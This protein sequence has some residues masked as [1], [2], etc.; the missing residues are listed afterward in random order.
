MDR[1]VSISS[2]ALLLTLLLIFTMGSYVLRGISNL[3]DQEIPYAKPIQLEEINIQDITWGGL[4]AIIIWPLI[5]SQKKK[6]LAVKE[7]ILH[8]LAATLVVFGVFNFIYV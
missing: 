8:A 2:L 3:S 6:L 1:K 5:L 7:E 4:A